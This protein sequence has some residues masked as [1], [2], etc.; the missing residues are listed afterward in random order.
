MPI[1]D[2]DLSRLA[3]IART[4]RR[5]RHERRTRWRVY[6]S[7]V[8]CVAL[9]QGAALHYVDGV[10]GVKDF[11]VWTFYAEHPRGPY[12][13]RWRTVADFGPSRFGRT[14]SSPELEGR[15][16]DLFGRSLPAAPGDEPGAVVSRYL[17]AA[18]SASAKLLAEKAVVLLEPSSRRG[19][20]LWRP[21]GA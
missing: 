11:D 17:G 19:E 18:R 2:E 14:P 8:L 5:A 1:A 15:R 13:A 3:E 6:D 7:R 10:N 4:D 12:P 21:A 9:C 16:V 20:I